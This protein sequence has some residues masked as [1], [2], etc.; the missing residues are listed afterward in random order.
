VTGD[1]PRLARRASPRLIAYAVLVGA[2]MLGAVATGRPAVVALAAPFALLLVAGAVLAEEP[3]VRAELGFE[4]DRCLEGDVVD[5]TLRLHVAPGRPRVEVLVGLDGR[6]SW[7]SES[8]WLR[9]GEPAE[10]LAL[11]VRADGWGLVTA[12]PAAVRVHGPLGLVRWEGVVGLPAS[13]RVLPAS[14]GLRDLLHPVEARAV[15]GVHPVRRRSAEGIEL[16]EIRPYAAGDELRWVNWAVSSRRG[17]LW[18]TRRQPE[19]M[20]D[21]VLVVDTFAETP[22]G[23]ATALVP[24]VRAAWLL[25]DAHLHAHDRV[26]IVGFGGYPTWIT[27]GSGDRTRYE[28]LDRL[29]ALQAHWTEAQRSF[30][31]LPRQVVPAGALVVGITPLHDERMVAALVDLRSRGH[32]VAALVVSPGGVARPEGE[33]AE[34]AWRLWQLVGERR[35]DDLQAAG[36]VVARWADGDDPQAALALLSLGRRRLAGGRR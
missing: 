10:P 14:G 21:L 12:G 8:S 24:A 31:T 26:G 30:R 9:R 29:L 5:A 6:A 35:A 27:P 22:A 20:G 25:T 3:E 33:R 11:A 16:A 4:T 1:G 23:L 28:V 34:L 18:V 36:V 7:A 32:D 15:A 2:G 19:H 13:L 17:A